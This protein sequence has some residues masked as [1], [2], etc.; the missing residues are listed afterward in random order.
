MA[1]GG[2][3]R[4]MAMSQSKTLDWTIRGLAA[5]IAIFNFAQLF[6][7]EFSQRVEHIGEALTS[8]I[9]IGL[10]LLVSSTQERTGAP[11]GIEK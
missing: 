11:R 10:L 1:G 6:G 2:G 4:L 3:V 7:V 8:L 5:A 9:L